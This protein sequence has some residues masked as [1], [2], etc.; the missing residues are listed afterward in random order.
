[1]VIRFH[2]L[3]SVGKP[4]KEAVHRQSHTKVTAKPHNESSIQV[5]KKCI[6]NTIRDI[7]NMFA[8]S[9][10]AVTRGKFKRAKVSVLQKVEKKRDQT[11]P[12]THK[13]LGHTRA[14]GI[15]LFAS[16]LRGRACVYLRVES[17][18]SRRQPRAV[19]TGGPRLHPPGQGN[20]CFNALPNAAEI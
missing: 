9:W 20:A 18:R 15:L 17:H 4:K 11:K 14:R 12:N 8:I 19:P 10:R 3:G 16:R 7:R 1:M 6:T 13:K 5:F 2:A